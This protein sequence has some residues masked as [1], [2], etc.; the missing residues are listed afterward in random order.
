MIAEYRVLSSGYF[1][2]VI[3]EECHRSIYG[4]WSG[5]LR[6]FDGIQLGL[7]ATPC[8]VDAAKPSDPEDGRFVRDTLRFFE[9]DTPTFR[10]RLR[11][12]IEEGYLAPYH[13]YKAM[14]V[15]T[16]AESGFEVERGELDWSAMDEATRTELEEL[17][18]ASD[19]IVRGPAGIGTEVHHPGTQPRN[20]TR[21]PFH[22]G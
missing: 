2:L 6:H 9:L 12:A 5:V 16:A 3:T 1:D 15:K 7:T 22:S 8:T 11:Q 14:T 20:G 21:V 17:F 10:Y 4:K 19:T 13:I 18:D